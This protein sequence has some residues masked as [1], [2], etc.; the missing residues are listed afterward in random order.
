[1]ALQLAITAYV[2]GSDT[3]DLRQI[4]HDMMDVFV[5]DYAARGNYQ[6]D[7]GLQIFNEIVTLVAGL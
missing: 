2:G 5:P 1:M 4:R 6:G 3:L 7:G